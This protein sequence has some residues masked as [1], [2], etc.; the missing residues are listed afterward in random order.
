M[1]KSK[2]IH[3]RYRHICVVP[4]S[5]AFLRLLYVMFVE[6]LVEFGHSRSTWQKRKNSALWVRLLFMHCL[7]FV[8]FC[9]ELLRC[10][11]GKK[12][13]R[14][15]QMSKREEIL[16]DITHANIF[17]KKRNSDFFLIFLVF[18]RIY[19]SS[20]ADKRGHRVGFSSFRDLLNQ[21]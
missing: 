16:Q 20:R 10:P 6:K 13:C 5:A 11:N 4:G 7:D 15:P 21:I 19:R 2:V 14:A 17:Q 8:F 12:F 18:S 3:R 9:H 1:D